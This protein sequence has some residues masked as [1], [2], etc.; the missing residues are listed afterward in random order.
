M[1]IAE[2]IA[3]VRKESD[4]KVKS[5]CYITFSNAEKLAEAF[6]P[7]SVFHLDLCNA[8]HLNLKTMKFTR[9][10]NMYLPSRIRNCAIRV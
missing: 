7:V 6:A 1:P 9:I 2:F 8:L 4:E 3:Q 10:L 5:L